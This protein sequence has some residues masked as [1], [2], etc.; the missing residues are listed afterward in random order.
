ML[1]FPDTSRIAD[2][3]I[4]HRIGNAEVDSKEQPLVALLEDADIITAVEEYDGYLKTEI[5]PLPPSC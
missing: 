3:I 4:N 5:K 2:F 1:I